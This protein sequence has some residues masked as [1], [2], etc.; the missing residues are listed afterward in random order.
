V[1]KCVRAVCVCVCV[2]ARSPPCAIAFAWCRYVFNLLTQNFFCSFSQFSHLFDGAL[3]VSSLL[4]VKCNK[5]PLVLVGLVPGGDANFIICCTERV[6]DLLQSQ[7]EHTILG[8]V[9][10]TYILLFRYSLLQ[11]THFYNI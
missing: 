5:F 6:P 11:T 7:W 3:N 8:T 9:Q 2:C 1:C 10:T 4:Y